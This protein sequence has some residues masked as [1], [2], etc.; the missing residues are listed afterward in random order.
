M[1]RLV[2]GPCGES[3]KTRVFNVQRIVSALDSMQFII[4]NTY[5]YALNIVDSIFRLLLIVISFPFLIPNYI[6][7]LLLMN[8]LKS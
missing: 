3:V 2:L 8:L 6:V 7:V 4:I 5:T 1:G